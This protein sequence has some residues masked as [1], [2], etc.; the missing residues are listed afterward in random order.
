[1]KSAICYLSWNRIDY[2]KKSLNSIIKN[3]NRDSYDLI[4]WDNGSD[5]ET[6]NYLRYTC[7]SNNFYYVF[8][9]KNFG[10]T[11]AMNN[12]M[13]I[14][15]KMNKYDVF[16]HIAN[17]IVVPPNWLNGVFN[18]ISS[19]KV[20]AVGINLEFTKFEKV[21]VDGI[22][23]EKIQRKGNLCGAHFCVPKWI[24]DLLG[25]FRHVELGYGQQDCNESL[26]IRCIPKEYLL[27]ANVDVFY[28]PLDDF[29]G[30]DL[31]GT[32]KVYDNYQ[33]N[34]ENRLRSSGSDNVGGRN[35]RSW[36]D[37]NYGHYLRKKITAKQMYDVLLDIKFVPIDKT[38]IKETNLDLSAI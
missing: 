30:E 28:L 22:T 19:K 31:G 37:L 13:R 7:K 21:I 38:H 29:R 2:M 12:Q 4:L 24:Y 26:R 6:L 23:L 20:G 5:D 1:M 35:Y 11:I 25:G 15:D 9:D 16:C 36:I 27:D 3:T 10:L 32:G 34:I 33:K 8:F 18:A 14:M 17:D